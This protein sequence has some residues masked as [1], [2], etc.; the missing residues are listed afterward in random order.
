M[1]SRQT[2]PSV[3]VAV[4]RGNTVLLVKRARPPSQ[5]VYAFPGGKVE[6]GESLETAAKRELLEE[7]GLDAAD[8]HPLIEIFID[9]S[10]EGHPVDYRLAVFGARYIGGEA[11]ADDDAETAAFYTLAE[12]ETMPLVGSVFS[13]AQD[14]LQPDKKPLG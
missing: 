12:M 11:K 13:V 3:S 14:L 5:G 8:L 4:V 2:I 1:T 6:A 7:T 9:G 10:V